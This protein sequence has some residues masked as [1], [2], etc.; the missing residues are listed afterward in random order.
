MILCHFGPF[1]ISWNYCLSTFKVESPALDPRRKRCPSMLCSSFACKRCTDGDR[2]WPQYTSPKISSL[3]RILCFIG[4]DGVGLQNWLF[5]AQSFDSSDS[6]HQV[7][8]HGSNYLWNHCV[9]SLSSLFVSKPW[10]SRES[11]ARDTILV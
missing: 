11:I 10:A 8:K 7:F 1:F 9:L 6:F 4:C 3:A 5:P 2:K